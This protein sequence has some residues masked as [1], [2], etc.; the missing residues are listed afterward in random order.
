MKF[1]SLLFSVSFLSFLVV[2]EALFGKV[3]RSSEIVFPNEK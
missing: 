1:K 3:D 2:G